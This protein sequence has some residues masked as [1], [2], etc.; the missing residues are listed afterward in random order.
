MAALNDPCPASDPLACRGEE[1]FRERQQEIHVRTDRMFANLMIVQ[2]IAGIVTA[3]WISPRAWEGMESEVHGHV[4][5]AVFLGAAVAS[6]PVWLAWSHPGAEIT[7]QTVA[8]GQVMSS[9]LLVHLAGGRI[10]TH[11]HIFGSLAFLAFYRDWK[12]LGTATSLIILDHVVRGAF[13]PQSIFGVAQASPWR[14]LE[15][16]GW[17]IFEDSFLWLSIRHGLR[18]SRL[19]ADRQARLEQMNQIIGE[20]VE[21][22]T[23]RLQEEIDE[24]GLAEERLKASL[25]SLAAINAVLDRAYLIAIT[26]RAGRITHAN[27]NFCRLSGYR[28][29]ELI[30]QNHR[31]LKSGEHPDSFFQQ[32]WQ[33]ITQGNVWRGEIR[34]RAKDGHTY[35]VD[36]AIGPMFD[37]DGKIKGYLAIRIEITE[38]IRLTRQLVASSRQA[39]MAEVAT[40]VLHNVGNVLNSVNVSC[41]LLSGRLRRSRTPGLHKVAKLLREKSAELPTFLAWDAHGEKLTSYLKELADQLNEERDA[42]AE[43]VGS[44]AKNI[45]HIKEI[46]ARQQSYA[47]IACIPETIQVA[48][49]I[50]DALE[51]SG[52]ELTQHA[53]EVVRE[54]QDDIPPISGDKHKVLQILVNFIRNAMHACTAS[55]GV[56]PR[57][58]VRCRQLNGWVQISVLDNGIGIP[59]ANL[60]RI[61]SHGFTTRQGGHGFGLHAGANAAKEMGARLTVHSD[62]AGQGATFTLELP[63]NA[64]PGKLGNSTH[65]QAC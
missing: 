33:T 51:M 11:F 29:E 44:L 7:R 23:R 25:S 8:V 39:G 12:V 9:A 24:R 36:T 55:E 20:R 41:R 27:E 43:E 34:N 57:I 56:A 28:R 49:L 6:L 5:A 60:N 15:H 54:L 13:W 38:R 1:I 61:F 30:G 40:G 63:M 65:D 4:W 37:E 17:V 64:I 46:V 45:D 58:T 59:Q 42:M 32:L 18:E 52:H 48:D 22:R 2:W 10:E 14:W 35:W 19:I 53:I 21:D 16:T 62:G 50:A 3:L 31:I 47:R 26:D